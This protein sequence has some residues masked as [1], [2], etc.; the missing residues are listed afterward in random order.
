MIKRIVFL[1]L[2]LLLIVCIQ[3]L[4]LVLI[5]TFYYYTFLQD[6]EMYYLFLSFWSFFI[7]FFIIDLIKT[8]KAIYIYFFNFCI[9][10]SIYFSFCIFYLAFGGSTGK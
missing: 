5:N 6:D 9:G 1:Y 3:L 4:D 2:H 8:K 10:F 7:V